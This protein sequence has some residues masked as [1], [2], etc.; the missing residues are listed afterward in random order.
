MFVGWL[1]STL[2][3]G[4][5]CLIIV[6]YTVSYIASYMASYILACIIYLMGSIYSIDCLL[7][8]YGGEG[9]ERLNTI[10]LLVLH[11]LS[12]V[13]LFSFLINRC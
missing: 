6:S 7:V 8:W 10:I 2:W 12:L 13:S 4:A 1:I 9:L 3:L 5:K 11:R